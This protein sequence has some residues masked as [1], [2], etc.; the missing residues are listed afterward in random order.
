MFLAG[1]GAFSGAIVGGVGGAISWLAGIVVGLTAGP[2]AVRVLC[3]FVSAIAT[4]AA[5]TVGWMSLDSQSN[6]PFLGSYWLFA[7]L[8]GG[9][10]GG[11]WATLKQRVTKRESDNKV[12]E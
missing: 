9:G 12:S 2:K 5:G 1:L 3:P 7:G 4:G 6:D 8:C 10:L 11:W